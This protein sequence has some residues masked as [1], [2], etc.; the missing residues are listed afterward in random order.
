MT[1]SII[2]SGNIAHFFATRLFAANVMLKQIYSPNLMHAIS[3]AKA[4]NATPTDTLY[5][6]DTNVDAIII[7]STDDAT[8]QLAKTLPVV[9]T[10]CI[11]TSGSISTNELLLENVACIWPIYSISQQN[12]PKP[13]QVINAGII[14]EE[15]NKALI[16]EI[17]ALAQLNLIEVSN[18]QKSI[19][20]LNATVLNNFLN[21]LLALSQNML[22]ENNLILDPLLPLLQ[23]T[24]D[25]SL[26]QNAK[27]NQTGPA[28][29]ND[30]NTIQKHLKMLENNDAL[31]NLYIAFTESIQALHSKK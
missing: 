27:K 8:L 20:H 3:L 11:Y 14:Y 19:L 5:T 13:S 24:I 1:I 2:G 10:L 16:Q 26:M 7:A 12:L 22:Q 17:G 15:K 23:S 9:N 30:T 31:K 25:K 29:R 4:V 18:E 21:H 28:L 6:F